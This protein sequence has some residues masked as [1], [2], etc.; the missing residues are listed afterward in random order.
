MSH[1]TCECGCIV[2]KKYHP[3]HIKTNKH[4][5]LMGKKQEEITKVEES[6][7]ENEPYECEVCDVL[8]TGKQFTRT[9]G[10]MDMSFCQYCYDNDK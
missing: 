2:T 1:I 6:D 4:T 8:V 10:C 5:N 3:T 7:E 9:Y